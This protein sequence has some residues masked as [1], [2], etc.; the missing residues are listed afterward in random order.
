MQRPMSVLGIG[1][2]LW[3]LFPDGPRLGGAPFNV[4]ANLRRLGHPA[5]F[6]TA[7]GNDDLGRAAMAAA[8]GLGID[9]DF[10]A[11]SPDLP[12]GTVDVVS[13]ARLGHRFEIGSPAA[14]ESLDPSGDVASRVEAWGP[15]ALVFGT[16]A[17]RAAGTLALT[18][19]VAA[20]AA[21]TPRLYDINLRMA[22]GHRSW[23]STS[24]RSRRS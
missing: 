4:T 11:V 17:Q 23:C 13:D 12:T 18:R 20:G 19:R 22:A 2:L 7:V 15:Q 6:V 3:D 21:A 10:V 24:S 14:Y 9:T 8:A 1:E 16:L 5:A